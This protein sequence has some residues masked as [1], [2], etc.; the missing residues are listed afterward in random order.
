V[1]RARDR[2]AAVSVTDPR[3]RQSLNAHG[4]RHPNPDYAID[5]D[6]ETAAQIALLATSDPVLRAASFTPVDRSAE[7]RTLT[8]EVPRL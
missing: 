8:I 7:A 2:N 3:R 1:K 5:L 4:G 6:E